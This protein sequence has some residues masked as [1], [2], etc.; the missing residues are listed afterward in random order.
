MDGFFNLGREKGEVTHNCTGG[1]IDVRLI[2][3]I[4]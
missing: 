4:P 3:Q 2:C 1:V